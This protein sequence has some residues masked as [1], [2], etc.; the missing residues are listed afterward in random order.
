MI[1]RRPAEAHVR[2]VPWHWEGDLTSG[3]PEPEPSAPCWKEPPG[4]CYFLHLPTDHGALAVE[5]VMRE[6][7]A[8]LPAELMHST[9]WDQGTQM[10]SHPSFA[11]INKALVR[12]YL[13]KGTDLSIHSAE[14]LKAIQ[15]SLN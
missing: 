7:I 5:T 3:K 15:R 1:G 9:T 13:P 4:P 14:D 11:T 2:A 12:Q 8:T 10:A 6:A